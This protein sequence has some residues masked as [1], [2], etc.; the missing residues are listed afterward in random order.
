MV[1]NQFGPNEQIVQIPGGQAEMIWKY[2]DQ[3]GWGPFVRGDRSFGDHFSMGTGSWGPEVQGSNGFRT[4][5]IEA[6][7]FTLY[8]YS[9]LNEFQFLYL[10]FH[11]AENLQRS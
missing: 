5:C 7:N 10:L 2:G 3:I 6:C 8:A 4:K 9:Y 11:W 1:P